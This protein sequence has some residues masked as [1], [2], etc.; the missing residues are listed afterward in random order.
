M[1]NRGCEDSMVGIDGELVF[2]GG[3]RGAGSMAKNLSSDPSPDA[4]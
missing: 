2:W 3:G 4:R 1:M